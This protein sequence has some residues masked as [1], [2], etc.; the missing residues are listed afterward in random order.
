MYSCNTAGSHITFFLY[1]S[2]AYIEII[3]NWYL[4]YKI[5]IKIKY[6]ISIIVF[7]SIV[8]GSFII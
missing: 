8:N 4:K 5:T 2:E 6:K 7:K 1:L 3:D